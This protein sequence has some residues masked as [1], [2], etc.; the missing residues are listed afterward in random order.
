M[1]TW[2][3]RQVLV[4]DEVLDLVREDLRAVEEAIRIESAQSFDSVTSISRY[5]QGNGSERVRATLLLLCARLAGGSGN[6]TAIQLGAVVE[7][8]HAAALVHGDV[9]DADKT[10]SASIQQANTASVLAGDLL[11]ARAFRVALEQHVLDLAIEAAQ[12]MAMGELIQLNRNGRIGITQADCM[13]VVALKTA[14]LFAAC[15]RM[16]AVAGGLGSR[17]AGIL[18][19]FAWNV[20]M[21]FQVIDDVLDFSRPSTGKLAGGNLENGKITL[22]LVYALQRGSDSERELVTTVLRDRSYEA[23]PFENVLAFV[24][25]HGGLHRS[26]ACARKYIDRSRQILA[27]FPDSG[28]RRSLLTLIDLVTERGS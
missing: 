20:G 17:D 23:A 8:L 27:E 4:A 28:Y 12:L 16:G 15:G 1:E 21:A 2:P 11:Y 14:S 25:R 13:E 6:R 19:E 7:M 18:G 22:P 5:L 10:A 26:R 9:V 3:A 24:V